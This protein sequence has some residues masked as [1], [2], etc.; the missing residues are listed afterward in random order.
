MA[1]SLHRDRKSN[2]DIHVPSL[3]LFIEHIHLRHHHSTLL[4]RPWYTKISRLCPNR[5]YAATSPAYH[6]SGMQAAPKYGGLRNNGKGR[7]RLSLAFTLPQRRIFFFFCRHAIPTAILC[8]STMFAG[9]WEA[10]KC[11]DFKILEITPWADC[12]THGIYSTSFSYVGSLLQGRSHAQTFRIPQCHVPS[13]L[14][15]NV[16]LHSSPRIQKAI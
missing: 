3:S 11:R 8:C 7:R 5:I 9:L 10:F 4:R 16:L 13:C 14:E 6:R 12:M 2:V 1:I 15:P